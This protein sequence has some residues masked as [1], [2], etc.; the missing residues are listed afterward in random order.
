[1]NKK[2]SVERNESV[3]LTEEERF[4]I[5]LQEISDPKN[6]SEVNY[7]LPKKPT[8]LQISKYKLCKQIL[9]YKLKFAKFELVL[10]DIELHLY[11]S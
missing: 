9:S 6:N 7:F 10:I 8:P 4:K 3:I 1:M 2:I 5:Y 11:F